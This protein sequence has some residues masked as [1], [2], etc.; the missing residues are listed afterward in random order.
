M[1][2]ASSKNSR[3]FA[4]RKEQFSLMSNPPS[5]WDKVVGVNCQFACTEEKEVGEKSIF[6]VWVRVRVKKKV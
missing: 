4:C 3:I 1:Q 5:K 2:F 6:R